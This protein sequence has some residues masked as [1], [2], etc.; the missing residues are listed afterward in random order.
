MQSQNSDLALEVIVAVRGAAKG[1]VSPRLRLSLL[2]TEE[3]DAK[4]NQAG[5]LETGRGQMNEVA[6]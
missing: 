6:L 2:V 5:F 4:H 3:E 1:A